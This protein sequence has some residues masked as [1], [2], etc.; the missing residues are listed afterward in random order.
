M[1]NAEYSN[2]FNFALG[3]MDLRLTFFSVE[4]Q[5]AAD[6]TVSG[7]DRTVVSKVVLPIQ[8]AKE[9]SEQLNRS[10]AAAEEKRLPGKKS[11][12]AEGKD[13]VR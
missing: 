3:E 13:D 11:F 7:E 9:L 1:N 6:G 5:F 4:P 10:F 8:L 2:A 12:D